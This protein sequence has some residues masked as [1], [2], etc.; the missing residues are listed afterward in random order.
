MENNPVL[1]LDSEACKDS[2]TQYICALQ[3]LFNSDMN[4]ETLGVF[5]QEVDRL[6]KVLGLSK[7]PKNYK[8]LKILER[9]NAI[10]VLAFLAV[11]KNSGIV[12]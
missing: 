9:D 4:E 7:V 3:R 11:Y 6:K 12:N 2:F 8:G 10:K 5:N 1:A